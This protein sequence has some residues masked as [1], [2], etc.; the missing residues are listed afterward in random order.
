MACRDIG[1]WVRGHGGVRVCN[2]RARDHQPSTRARIAPSPSMSSKP[3]VE[4][5]CLG[6]SL[7]GRREDRD[8]SLGSRSRERTR[9]RSHIDRDGDLSRAAGHRLG[10]LAPRSSSRGGSPFPDR[11]PGQRPR[12]RGSRRS[13]W[14]Q[15]FPV[16]AGAAP[17]APAPARRPNRLRGRSR[18]GSTSGCIRAGCCGR[19]NARSPS[20]TCPVSQMAW[21]RFARSPRR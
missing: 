21:V 17:S 20:G 12:R 3:R 13:R 15:G 11:T 5:A 7:V 8:P 1:G 6:T 19:C 4:G 16:G 14:I 2:R 10:D 18:S 9:D